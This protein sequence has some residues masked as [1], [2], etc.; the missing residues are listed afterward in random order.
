MAVPVRTAGKL[1]RR[2]AFTIEA[3]KSDSISIV[4]F[5]SACMSLCKHD[6]ASVPNQGML[7]SGGSACKQT[8]LTH[9]LGFAPVYGFLRPFCGFVRSFCSQKWHEQRAVLTQNMLSLGLKGFDGGKG[10]K[11]CRVQQL[12]NNRKSGLVG[13]IKPNEIESS[14]Q[15]GN[16]QQFQFLGVL[17]WSFWGK[18][19]TKRAKAVQ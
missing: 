6:P 7:L 2:L 4:C 18:S 17:V 5:Y 9:V 8:Q 3:T 16:T 12:Q 19:G 15:K 10:L 14:V 11:A 13:N 1:V